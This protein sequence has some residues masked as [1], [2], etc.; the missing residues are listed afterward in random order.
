VSTRTDRAGGVR[1]RR[2]LDVLLLLLAAVVVGVLSSSVAA[3][4]GGERVAQLW[5]GATVADDGSARITEVIDWNF[6][7]ADRHGIVRDVPGLRT[8]APIE[9][10]SP[11]APD[12]VVVSTTGT[13]RI[14]I[15][16]PSRTVSGLHRYV[17]A[18]T[19]DGVVRGDRLAWNAVGTT[20][21]VPIEHVEVHVAAPTLL[22]DAACTTGTAGSRA[23]CTTGSAEPGQLVA[24]VDALDA[25]VGVT[26]SATTGAA[27]GST[28]ALPAPAVA[29]PVTQGVTPFLPGV[30]AGGLALL[31][32]V[33]VSGVIRRAGREYVPTVGVP[34]TASPGGRARIDL[35]ELAGYVVASPSLPAGLTPAEGGVLVAGRVLDQHKAAWLV[36]QAVDGVVDLA[37]DSVHAD[38]I[39]MNRL[40]SGD[41]AAAR[42]LDIAFRG[43]DQLTLGVFDRDFARMW[44]ALGRQLADWQRESG[45]W[46][47]DGDRR[48][49]WVRVVGTL[50]G[51]AGL[52]LA[53]VGG[54]LAARQADVPLMISGL[55][56]A[57]AGAGAAAAVRGWEL[58]VFTPKGSAAW[59]QVASLTQFFAQSPP[60][61][62]DEV[63]ASRQ[64]GR[65]TAWAVALGE[66]QRWSQL[67]SGLSD[68][69]RLP[70]DTRGLLYAG[71]AP[72]FVTHCCTSSTASSASSGGG[73]VSVGGGAG[74][75]GAGSW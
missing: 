46:D 25:G 62:L 16:D 18:Y 39:T 2:G 67:P 20:W 27:L 57:L 11:D 75:G 13:P 74:G 32:A 6:G 40:K 14:R 49:R 64:I 68:S 5:V 61:A 44:D 28:S 36:G 50:V 17:V 73:G 34:V 65:Y 29:A 1:R 60:T 35:A 55:G 22:V 56:G 47:A 42:L 58:R 52:V 31:T 69:A 15:G 30:L 33:I 4:F 66:A 8:S 9:V 24:R 3:A 51:V 10:S 54:Y 70:Y 59:L 71:Y 45:L 21:E 37:P 19:L 41:G 72:M 23:A 7:P 63:I 12:D 48:A 26:V 43:R 38:Q 53:V